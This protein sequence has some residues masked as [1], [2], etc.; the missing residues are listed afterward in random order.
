MRKH[1]IGLLKGMRCKRPEN[2]RERQHRRLNALLNKRWLK[3]VRAYL[4]K[5]KFQLL[6]DY[7]SPYWARWYLRR[8][9]KGAMR[10]RLAPLKRF[11]RTLRI[12]EALIINWFE[13]KKAFSSGAVEGMN[14][15][16]NLITR[17]T[18]G[19]RAYET[20]KIA[21]FHTLGHLPKPKSAHR[22]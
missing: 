21:L 16:F 3:T 13:A 4:W 5:E 14:R 22:F 19:F 7:T 2:L 18:Y 17:K 12:H 1:G 8:W 15:K 10:S 9:C 11:V 20:L 6:W